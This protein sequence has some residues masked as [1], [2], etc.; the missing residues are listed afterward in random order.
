[1]TQRI[2]EETM[3][4]S[5]LGRLARIY[6]LGCG[7]AREVENFLPNSL[8]DQA[9][10][11]LMDFDDETLS[12]T[13]GRME[14]ARRANHRSTRFKFVKK[15]V[16]YLL[17]ESGKP[18]NPAEQFDLIYS[19]GLYD[20]LNDRVSRTVNTHLYDQL[21]PG[22]VLIISNFEPSNPI[23]NLMEYA[24]E[25]FLIHRNSCQMKAIGPSQVPPEACE[26]RADPT[27]CNVFLEV[28]KPVD[29]I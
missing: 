28:R 15:S 6:S 18:A 16:Y 24:F 21:S 29:A 17:K 10:F 5:T 7:P 4:V 11:Q 12:Y 23:R 3:R 8:A 13:E 20:Y 14:A 25:W 27:G 26:V 1:M 2:A 19:S 22:G 9:V